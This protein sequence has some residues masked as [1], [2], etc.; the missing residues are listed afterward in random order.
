MVNVT[1]MTINFIDETFPLF[2][3]VF[4]REFI[5]K[6]VAIPENGKFRRNA[7]LHKQID[8]FYFYFYCN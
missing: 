5:K 7:M 3:R 6:I 8:T 2:E 4:T 1:L